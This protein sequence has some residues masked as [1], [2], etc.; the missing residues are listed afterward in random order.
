MFNDQTSDFE[1]LLAESSKICN[2]HRNIQTLMTEA[3]K[4]QNNLVSPITEAMLEIKAIP[5]NLRNPQEFVMQRNRTV[6]YGLKSLSN[7]VPKFWSL[8]L[9]EYK[10]TTS[11]NQFTISLKNWIHTNCPCR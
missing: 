1:T 5:Y 3:Y 7:Q 2:H 6:H 10:Q 11:L 9:G 8:V 4:I